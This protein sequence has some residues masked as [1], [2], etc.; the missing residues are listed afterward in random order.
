MTE[1]VGRL[2]EYAV[3]KDGRPLGVP[4]AAAPFEGN[5]STRFRLTNALL[6]GSV[7]FGPVDVLAE[8]SHSSL[9]LTA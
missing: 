7:R 2:A 9:T 4:C 8:L 1:P 6:H 3:C 5:F